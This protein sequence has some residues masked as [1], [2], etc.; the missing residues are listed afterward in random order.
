MMRVLHVV[1]GLNVGGTETWLAKGIASVDRTR[2]AFDFLVH[3][4]TSQAYEDT[5]RMNGGRV[6]RIESR[7]VAMYAWRLF[8]LLRHGE[9]DVVHAHVYCFS[10]L[11]LAI[12]AWAGVR[13]RIFQSH[14]AQDES[15]SRGWRAVYFRIARTLIQTY[16]TR[17]IAVSEEAAKAFFP[18]N[19]REEPRRWV[20]SPIGIDLSAFETE[21]DRKSLREQLRI[22]DDA[23]AVIQ[24]GRFVAVKNHALLLRI[25]EQ[26]TR[27]EP[28]FVFIVVG[29][30]P[31]REEIERSARDRGLEDRFRF[32]GIRCDVAHLLRASDVFVMPSHYEGLPLA[33]LEAQAAGLPCVISDAIAPAAYLVRGRT[34]RCSVVADPERWVNALRSAASWERRE[35]LG[36]EM[37]AVSLS[38]SMER[39]VECYQ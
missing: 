6:L 4:E 20:I 34:I 3:Q 27:V 32:T 31:L 28:R 36:S 12:A 38:R 33:Y 10:A 11:V 25:A 24:V 1:G 29:D 37:Q 26:G 19:W 15:T 18:E 39:M 8:R 16:C 5:V 2:F 17:G 9:Y 21:C 35:M 23:I 22:A 14:T 13:V 30:G 7:N